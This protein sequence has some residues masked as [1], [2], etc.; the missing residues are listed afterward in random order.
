MKIENLLPENILE[1][2]QNFDYA[3]IINL[4]KTDRRFSNL[5][6]LPHFQTSIM[7][8]RAKEFLKKIYSR[9]RRLY[10]FLT[11]EERVRWKTFARFHIRDYV[12]RHPK[13]DR[14]LMYT[15]ASNPPTDR[16]ETNVNRF[17]DEID[18]LFLIQNPYIFKYTNRLLIDI[19]EEDLDTLLNKPK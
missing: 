12:A 9:N 19:S 15:I 8:L 13:V 1:I 5:C 4:C 3:D 17:L 11:N 2:V 16:H 18:Y 14:V 6:K 10:E 7:K